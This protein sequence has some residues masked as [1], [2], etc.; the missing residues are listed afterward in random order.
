MAARTAAGT[1]ISFAGFTRRSAY[2]DYAQQLKNDSGV[3]LKEIAERPGQLGLQVCKPFLGSTSSHF[4]G[5][6]T[7]Q[8][9][10][11]GLPLQKRLFQALAGD[12]LIETRVFA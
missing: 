7:N 1:A 10:G 3:V 11:I 2:V 4:S 12:N 5:F 9:S 6:A 8:A